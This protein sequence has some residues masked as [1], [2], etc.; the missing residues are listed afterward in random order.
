MS[1][2]FLRGKVVLLE[3]DNVWHGRGFWPMTEDGDDSN[4]M[5]LCAMQAIQK[6]IAFRC[7]IGP[8]GFKLSI[9]F[10]EL[11]GEE[12][13]ELAFRSRNIL[14]NDRCM[15]QWQ[16]ISGKGNG[17]SSNGDGR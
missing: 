17:G 9:C 11:E 14:L 4:G 16:L 15:V 3:G 13:N 1:K 6:A 2:R 12:A 5:N 7:P 10:V 8:Y